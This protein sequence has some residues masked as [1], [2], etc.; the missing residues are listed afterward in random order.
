M[1]VRKQQLLKQHRR[2]KRIAL[3]A[4]I[5]GLLLLGFIAPL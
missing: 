5:M 3:L 1:S 4:I 2:N